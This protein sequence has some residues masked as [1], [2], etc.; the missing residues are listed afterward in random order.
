MSDGGKKK[1]IKLR[2]GGTSSAN[3]RAGSPAPAPVRAGSIGAEGSRAGSPAVQQ[4]MPSIAD[5]LYKIR[6]F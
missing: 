2:L 6:P 1:K 4:S 3:S 5:I